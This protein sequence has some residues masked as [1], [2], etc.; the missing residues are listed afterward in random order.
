[1][2]YFFETYGCQ[3][4]KAESGAAQQLLL[5][6]GWL[7]AA[8]PEEC[9]LAIIN[10]CSV[11]ETAEIRIIGRLGW[12]AGLKAVRRG[13]SGAKTD[14]YKIAKEKAQGKPL[15]LIVMGCMAQRLL[16]TLKKDY[17]V[18]DYAVGTF[19]KHKIADIAASVSNAGA[20]DFLPMLGVT[21]ADDSDDSA[22]SEYAFSR[23][24]LEA[25]AHSAYVPV[26]HGCNNFC[27]YCIVPYVRGREVSRNPQHILAELD[28]LAAR[29]AKEVTFLSQNVNSYRFDTNGIGIGIVDFPQL[30]ETVATHLAKTD[31]PIRW[32]RFLSSHPKDLSERLVDLVCTNSRFCNHIHLPLQSGSTKILSEMNRKYSAE[33]YLEKIAMMRQNAQRHALSLAIT[34][35]ILTGFPGETDTDFEQT[36]QILRQVEFDAAFTYYYNPRSGTPAEKMPEQ[37]PLS[38]KK[39]RLQKIV[40]LQLHITR[41]KMKNR[42]G[43]T[44]TVLVN[45]KARRQ[46]V[47]IAESAA[48]FTAKTKDDFRVVFEAPDSADNKVESGD[49]VELTLSELTGNTFYGILL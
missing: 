7:P 22:D 10:T 12:Y 11:R 38:V 5:D 21:G 29:G 17:P 28:E 4:N 41:I 46:K 44:E 33:E 31:S 18:I 3:M 30:M 25:G 19:Q 35:D 40:E 47:G 39:E 16:K 34:T 36:L 23:L 43:R 2:T 24:S 20:S 8:S 26:M 6:A 42:L 9:D 37:L 49:F 1:M 27:T 45:S 14:A 13:A 32:L 15:T 48:T